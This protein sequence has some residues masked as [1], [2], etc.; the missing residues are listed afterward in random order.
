LTLR[1][2]FEEFIDKSDKVATGW[3]GFFWG[4]TPEDLKDPKTIGDALTRDWLL[5]FQKKRKTP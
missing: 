2:E 1:E 3:I 5:F 4:Q